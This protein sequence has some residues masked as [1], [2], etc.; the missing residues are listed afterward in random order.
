MIA[1]AG[2]RLDARIEARPAA[3]LGFCAT[4]VFYGLLA[5]LPSSCF[6]VLF[7]DRGWV[8]YVLVLFMG[9]CMATLGLKVRQMRKQKRAMLLDVLPDTISEEITVHNVDNNFNC[10]RSSI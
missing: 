3:L 4:G 2:G 1:G 8:P 10:F 9:W 7:P 6:S 5:L